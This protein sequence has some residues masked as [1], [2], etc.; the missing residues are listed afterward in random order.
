M[1]LPFPT[2]LLAK[3]FE[4]MPKSCDNKKSMCNLVTLL[5]WHA[6]PVLNGFLQVFLSETPYDTTGRVFYVMSVTVRPDVIQMLPFFASPKHSEKVVDPL[7][8]R[9]LNTQ[10]EIFNLIPNKYILRIH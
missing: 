1:C 3:K 4:K 10:S 6:P 5:S 9:L 2:H 7:F 8:I